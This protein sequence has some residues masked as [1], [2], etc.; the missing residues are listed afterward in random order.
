MERKEN[1]DTN[2]Q[3][4]EVTDKTAHQEEVMAN[5]DEKKAR[6]KS[7]SKHRKSWKAMKA[8]NLETR[9]KT[10]NRSRPLN[11]LTHCTKT[12]REEVVKTDST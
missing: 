2:V 6:K 12:A 11:Q 8:L 9:H 1:Q 10:S 3:P 7:R 4:E 5:K